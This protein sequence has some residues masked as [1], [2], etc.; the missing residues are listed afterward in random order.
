[1]EIEDEIRGYLRQ[2]RHD[3]GLSQ[4][5]LGQR[6][7]GRSQGYVQKL[8]TGE[9]G[10][11]VREIIMWSEACGRSFFFRWV[12]PGHRQTTELDGV[13]MQLP[14]AD[15]ERLVDVAKILLG[16]DGA[17]RRMIVLACEVYRDQ[18]AKQGG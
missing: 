3:A 12:R 16:A 14:D 9:I 11:S 17:A 8:E 15:M 6:L 7:G 5:A 10:L 18:R 4:R 2:L 13:A 1:M